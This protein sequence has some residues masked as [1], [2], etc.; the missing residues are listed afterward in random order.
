MKKYS[1]GGDRAEQRGTKQ[2][3]ADDFAEN[4]RLTDGR[5]QPAKQ[6]ADDDDRGQRDQQVEQDVLR[7]G[8][9]RGDHATGNRR[10]RGGQRLAVA[11]DEQ[12]QSARDKNHGGVRRCRP[13]LTA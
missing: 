1:L 4:R 5:E 2:D 8:A 7:S 12:E 9:G 3:A 10:R 13:H 6:P 11:T